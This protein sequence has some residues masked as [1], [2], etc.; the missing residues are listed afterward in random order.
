[1]IQPIPSATYRVQMR[2]GVTFGYVEER[3]EYLKSL[4][5]S[6]LYLSPIFAA[7]EGSTHG[8]DILDPTEI[9]PS[10]G[11]R[12]G[13][14][15]LARAAHS[16]GIGIILDIVPNHT[17]F[18]LENAWLQDVLRHGAK[19][20]F[21]AYFDIDWAAGPLV[22]PLLPE[23]FEAMLARGDFTVTNGNWRFGDNEVPLAVYHDGNLDSADDLSMLHKQQHW[24]L[25]HWELERDGIT[26]RRFFNVTSLI[27]MRVE[28]P[29]VFEATHWLIIDLVRAG[30]VDCLRIDHIDGLADPKGYLD[31]LAAVLPDTPV[32]VEK[33]LVG[34]EAL[35]RHWKTV[36]TTGY[37]AAR[38]I[39]RLLTKADGIEA[40][41]AQW[42]DYTGVGEDFS[43]A[44]RAAKLEILHNELS[45]ELHQ[46]SALAGASLADD[47]DVE[48]GPEGLREAVTE[49]LL[50]MPRYRT[51]IDASGASA[52]ERD[53][54]RH[55]VDG[56]ENQVRSS[57]IVRHLARHLAN[58]GN[59]ADRSFTVRFQQVSAA[60][61]AKSQEDTA[62]FR[63]T[64]YLA[65]NEV[66]AEPEQ[67]SVTDA[68]ANA[69]L[70]ERPASEMTLTS[71][72]D[73][74]RSEDSRMRL[75]AISHHPEAFVSLV[76][77]ADR[78]ATDALSRRW[79]W[80]IVQSS[81]A[82][83]GEEIDTI[84]ERLRQHNQKALREAKLESFWTKPNEVV[85]AAA[86]RFSDALCDHWQEAQPPEL[87]QLIETGEALA[88]AQVA[89]KCLLPGFPDIYR[90]A[91]GPFFALTDPDNRLPVDWQTLAK[92]PETEGFG[93]DKAR[94]TRLLLALRREEAP[95][96]STAAA[97][98][99]QGSGTILAR[100]GG[101]RTLAITLG[102]PAAGA[103]IWQSGS[104]DYALVIA[105]R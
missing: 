39:A 83:W 94:L 87:K 72:H 91:E 13:F 28:D 69:F 52:E 76:Q 104:G 92:L 65:A 4:G 82:L 101:G 18:T 8:Y 105:W 29:T 49:L 67:T 40:L 5:I 3:L 20:P 74:K 96:F 19:S 68:E 88:L 30:L 12:E 75:V 77:H 2:G 36:G 60:L 11:G 22:L 34:N 80:Y 10:L 55:I 16:A 84:K 1:M 73:T 86:D 100:I 85:E 6:H 61:L 59:S 102:K 15:K 43:A 23:P 89:L 26:H 57:R 31:Q 93:G 58:P 62:G 33:I 14:E 37:E 66:G 47:P 64:R 45:A 95:F 54:L 32:W 103:P 99:E 48:P 27:G 50:G 42:R 98:V 17:A 51:Y 79:R 78:L 63:W 21:A 24:R 25:R 56:A 35:D 46:L 90:G 71:S 53:L 7:G 97:K 41:D 81:L 38:L 70:A 44:L 9:E